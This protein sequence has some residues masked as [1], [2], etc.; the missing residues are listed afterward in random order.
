[1]TMS[2][3]IVPV[4]NSLPKLN[5]ES[6]ALSLCLSL[7]T[8]A[9]LAQQPQPPSTHAES[10]YQIWDKLL[11]PMRDGGIVS[12]TV[13]KKKDSPA[14]LPALLTVDIYT[15]PASEIARAK[16]A[17]DHGYVGVIA[18]TR[19]RFVARR[20][21]YFE[22]KL[23]NDRARVQRLGDGH[24]RTKWL[25]MAIQSRKAPVPQPVGDRFDSTY[26]QRLTSHRRLRSACKLL[27]IRRRIFLSDT[28][29]VR[30][31][32]IPASRTRLRPEPPQSR[33]SSLT[34][35]ATVTNCCAG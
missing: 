8:V 17:A 32:L 23:P 20:D 14:R 16:D 25:G 34:S 1:M 3:R 27:T 4:S 10:E 22:K 30:P 33:T 21:W 26:N 12:A 29:S 24:S 11:I 9:V 6:F 28:L 5:L 18:D 35:G 19:G 13:A 2:K 31:E 15:D 7:C